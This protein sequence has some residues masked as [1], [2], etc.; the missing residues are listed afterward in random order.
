MADLSASDIAARCGADGEFR[1]AVQYWTGGYRIEIG[2]LV[3]GVT[4]SGGE[5][6]E[7]VP[8]S[9]PGVISLSGGA[10]VWQPM[11]QTVP[12]RLANTVSV[13][14]GLG[15]ELDADPLLWWQYL[16]ATERL[17]ELMRAP[18]QAGPTT[19]PL[20]ILAISLAVN[21]MTVVSH[22]LWG[23]PGHNDSTTTVKRDDPAVS[24]SSPVR[25]RVRRA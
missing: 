17:T 6:V 22:H 2:D 15:L 21:R 23:C 20:V 16:P 12:P 1:L 18:G 13:M 7:G 14:V 5:I 19:V 25:W 10:D 11:L 4:I 24:I 3:T 8:A 9:G